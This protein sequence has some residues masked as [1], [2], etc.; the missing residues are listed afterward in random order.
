MKKYLMGFGTMLV[1]AGLMFGF[2]HSEVRADSRPEPF[3]CSGLGNAFTTNTNLVYKEGV[4][5][6]TV[7]V[8][9]TDKYLIMHCRAGKLDCGMVGGSI[10]CINSG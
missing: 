8:E 3:I 5:V 10:S 7:E 2:T 1:G 4:Q 6:K 9:E